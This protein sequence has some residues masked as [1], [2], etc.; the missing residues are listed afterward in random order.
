MGE[1]GR[2]RCVNVVIDCVNTHSGTKRRSILMG[3]DDVSC[4]C[5]CVCMCVCVCVCVWECVCVRACVC[6]CVC[7][8]VFVHVYMCAYIYVHV[9][10][11]RGRKWPTHLLRCVHVCD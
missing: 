4:T 7:V 3:L 8:C 10:V 1:N 5:A 2:L 9:C 11:V 6:V